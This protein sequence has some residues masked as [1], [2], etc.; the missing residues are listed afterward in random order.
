MSS[1]SKIDCRE[2]GRG[3]IDLDKQAER[4]RYSA[5]I[6]FSNRVRLRE[7]KMLCLSATSSWYPQCEIEYEVQNR[8]G[9]D[10]LCSWQVGWSHMTSAYLYGHRLLDRLSSVL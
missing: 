8:R 5:K 1:S 6:S 4:D 10:K 2:V 7:M 9:F 3:V